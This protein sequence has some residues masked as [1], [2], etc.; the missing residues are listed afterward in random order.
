MIHYQSIK[1]SLVICFHQDESEAELIY[2]FLIISRGW[3]W[4]KDKQMQGALTYLLLDFSL[5]PPIIL[6]LHIVSKVGAGCDPIIRKVRDR[7]VQM[8]V[9]VVRWLTEEWPELV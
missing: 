1:V 3:C 7:K 2:L 4:A 6:K 9:H 8:V 5:D